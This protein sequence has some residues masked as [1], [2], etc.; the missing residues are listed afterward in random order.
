MNES[1][2]GED[3]SNLGVDN[4]DYEHNSSSSYI[5]KDPNSANGKR[6]GI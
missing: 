5:S 6:T 3:K 1:G 2:V 4:V